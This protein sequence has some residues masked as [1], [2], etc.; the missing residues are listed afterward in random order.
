[1]LKTIEN[2]PKN[3]EDK[4]KS[5][6]MEEDDTKYQKN[7]INSL[8]NICIAQYNINPNFPLDPL[9][10]DILCINCYE[11]VKYSE[12]DNHSEICVVRPDEG[13]IILI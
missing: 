2:N 12:V 5:I 7:I 13:K 3:N 6:S 9:F 10:F 1:M 4:D 11:C 8:D